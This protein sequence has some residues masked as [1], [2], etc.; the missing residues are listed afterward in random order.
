[1][2]TLTPNTSASIVS[3]QTILNRYRPVENRYGRTAGK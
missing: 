1:M 2:P 3:F